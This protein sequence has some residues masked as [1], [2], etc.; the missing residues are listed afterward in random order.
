MERA[1]YLVFKDGGRSSGYEHARIGLRCAAGIILGLIGWADERRCDIAGSAG[2]LGAPR[3]RGGRNSRWRGRIRS[4]RIDRMRGVVD[5][6]GRSGRCG[7]GGRVFE[8]GKLH[9]D[10]GHAEER[11]S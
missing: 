1:A 11:F 6:A 7:F 2:I 8:P 9:H 4:V 3:R 5:R 10:T